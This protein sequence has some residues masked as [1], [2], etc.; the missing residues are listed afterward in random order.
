M[1]QVTSDSQPFIVQVAGVPAYHS[2]AY[3]LG[4]PIRRKLR[5]RSQNLYTTHGREALILDWARRRGRASSTEVS[6]LTGLSVPYAGTL[7]TDLADRGLLVGSRPEKAG[8]GYHYLPSDVGES[9]SDS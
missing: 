9:P 1:R 5:H 8:R 2:P 4:S 6:D 7:L 3:R